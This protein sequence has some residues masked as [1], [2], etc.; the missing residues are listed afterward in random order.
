MFIV[1]V[2]VFVKPEYRD[3]FIEA[4]LENAR[5]TRNEPKNLR[6]DVLQCLDD[7]DRFFLYEV[8]QDETGMNDHK[9]TSHYQKWRE[10]VEEMMAKPREGIKHKNLFPITE[11]S[12]LSK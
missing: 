3:A 8:Y 10:T 1:C 5:N 6:F 2:T 12:F 11:E 7:P 9:T 4:S